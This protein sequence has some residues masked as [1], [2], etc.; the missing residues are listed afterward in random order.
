M[1]LAYF[2][3][4]GKQIAFIDEGEGEPIVLIHG[5]A[6]NFVTNWIG[7]GW[8]KTLTDAGYRVL[9]LDNRGHGRSFKSHDP[10]DYYPEKMA[11]DTI[12]LLDHLRIRRAH[13]KGY[14]MGARISAF[15]ALAQP[16]RV[17]SLVFGGLGINLVKGVGYWEPVA[18]ALL[19]DEPETIT[20][21]NALAFR[22]FAEQTRS[23]RKALAACIQTSREL[24]TRE[25][26]RSIE[27][28]ALVAVGT[29][30]DIAG[31]ARELADLL[32]NGVAFDIEG[33]DHMLSVGD[34]RFK[35]KVIGFLRENAL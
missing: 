14:S 26:I 18:E 4:G 15:V 10:D 16:G 25:Q 24:V 1:A 8:V 23:D 35:E 30:D 22:T 27:T 3:H 12:A 9:A 34:R 32:P 17:A 11:S 31:S 13:I 5:F 2:S 20:D 28:P 29:K 21:K 6:S 7:P 19:T 33:R